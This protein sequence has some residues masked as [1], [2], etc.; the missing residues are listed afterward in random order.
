MQHWLQTLSKYNITTNDTI[1]ASKSFSIQNTA[2]WSG[3]AIMSL[4]ASSKYGSF[5]NDIQLQL[6]PAVTWWLGLI[7]NLPWA[8]L[9]N[10][11]SQIGDPNRGQREML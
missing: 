5:E 11:L 3:M 2:K 8:E 7:L 10:I 6:G 4:R 1:P 9:F